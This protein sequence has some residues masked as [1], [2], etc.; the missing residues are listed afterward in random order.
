MSDLLP[1]QFAI[2]L[3]YPCRCVFPSTGARFGTSRL[4]T[5]FL[6][7]E[8]VELK[9]VVDWSAVRFRALDDVS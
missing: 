3:Q 9:L 6:N 7:E 4:A 1:L 5:L 8:L 2:E